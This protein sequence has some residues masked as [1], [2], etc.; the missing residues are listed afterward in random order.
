MA[1]SPI[2]LEARLH[3]SWAKL[4]ERFVV[5]GAKDAIV[6]TPFQ[7]GNW[8]QAWY[9]TLGAQEGVEP[10]PLEICNA[11]TGA[12]VFGVPLIRRLVGGRSVIEFADGDLTDYNAPLLAPVHSAQ[13]AKVSAADL[14]KLLL[15]SFPKDDQ[16]RLVKMPKEL[17]GLP[18]PF[19]RLQGN[20]VCEF[21][22]N[23]VTIED[24]WPTYRKRLA[25]KVRK[26]LERSFRVFERDG[27][28]ARFRIIQDPCEALAVLERMESLQAARMRELGL[29]FVLN[30]PQFAAFYRRLIEL[31]LHNGHLVLSVL[32][33]DP[34]EL[35]GALLGLKDGNRYAMVRLAHAGAAWSHCSPGKLMID[36]TMAHLHA[37]GVTEFDFTTGD[38]NYKKGF[39]T[40][41]EALVNVTMGVS[42]AGRADWFRERNSEL[43]KSHLRRYPKLFAAL[44]GLRGTP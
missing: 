18:N 22:T 7:R 21:G 8:L 25:K 35:V 1:V 40:E 33:S 5:P 23:V 27:S 28:N 3:D 2:E 31:D 42:M 29:P 16:L 36:R 24:D 9:D 11:K 34:D 39:L 26:E 38:Y 6:A 20:S 19:A 41:S 4:V 32:Q 10:V 43:A 37:E 15:N 44:K 17:A 12:P 30:E 14:R 13:A